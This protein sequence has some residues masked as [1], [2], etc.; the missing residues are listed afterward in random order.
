MKM[1]E[2]LTELKKEKEDLTRLLSLR[3]ETFWVEGN[4]K[5]AISTAELTARIEEKIN[6]VRK[7]KLKIQEENLKTKVGEISLAEAI[8]KI[9]D[10]RNE[11]KNLAE[12]KDGDRGWALRDEKEH[13]RPQLNPLQI[14]ELVEKLQKQKTKLDSQIQSVN[15]KQEIQ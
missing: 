6:S 4:K 5:P 15:W 14:E 11:T 13:K 7:M 10:L 9:A 3:K 2:M 8:L 12:L 1:G